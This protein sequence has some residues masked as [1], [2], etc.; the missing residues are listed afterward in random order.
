MKTVK[1]KPL[2]LQGFRPVAKLFGQ[3]A[4]QKLETLIHT[5]NPFKEVELEVSEAVIL[6]KLI[7]G[8]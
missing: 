1:G 5:D 6:E 3:E 8:R 7:L 2:T 4:V